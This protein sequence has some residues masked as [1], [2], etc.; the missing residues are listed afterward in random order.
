MPSP[1]NGLLRLQ[2]NN[3]LKSVAGAMDDVIYWFDAGE[4][5]SAKVLADQIDLVTKKLAKINKMAER[6]QDVKAKNAIAE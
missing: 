3:Y 1:R 4:T 5:L 2:R 6:L